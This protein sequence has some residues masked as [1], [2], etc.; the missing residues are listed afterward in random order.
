MPTFMPDE[1]QCAKVKPRAEEFLGSTTT[2]AI[3]T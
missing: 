1:E 2:T 3:K